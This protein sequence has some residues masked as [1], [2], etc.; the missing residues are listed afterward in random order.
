VGDKISIH[1][2]NSE[3]DHYYNYDITTGKKASKLIHSVKSL[4]VYVKEELESFNIPELV[5]FLLIP[6]LG[7]KDYTPP[8]SVVEYLLSLYEDKNQDIQAIYPLLYY[9]ENQKY[10]NSAIADLTTLQPVEIVKEI[11]PKSTKPN[12]SK[13]LLK[14]LAG[15]K[16][17]KKQ[18]KQTKKLPKKLAKKEPKK[19]TKKPVKLKKTISIPKTDKIPVKLKSSEEKKKV[20]APTKVK[21]SKKAKPSPPIQDEIEDLSIE[22]SIG[23]A[24]SKPVGTI[25][26]EK[27]EEIISAFDE[28]DEVEIYTPAIEVEPKYAKIESKIASVMR[29][30]REEIENRKRQLYKEHLERDRVPFEPAPKKVTLE[31]PSQISGEEFFGF[32]NIEWKQQAVYKLRNNPLIFYLTTISETGKETKLRNETTIINTK[33]AL[34]TESSKI[35]I[36]IHL[37]NVTDQFEL[38]IQAL[39]STNEILF[40]KSITMKRMDEITIQIEEFYVTGNYGPVESVF[41]AINKGL[42]QKGEFNMFLAGQTSTELI[43]IYSDKFNL[44]SNQNLE[45]ARSVDFL[46]IYHHSPF[47]LVSQITIGRLKKTRAYKAITINPIDD[48]LIEWDYTVPPDKPNLK[49]DGVLPKTKYEV[50][51]LFHFNRPLPPLTLTVYF[52]TLPEG[53]TQKLTTSKIKR[54]IDPGDEY[55]INKVKFKTPKNCGYMYFGVEILTDQGPIPTDLVSEPIGVPQKVLSS[56]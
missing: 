11:A 13:N 9:S 37:G 2:V 21:K 34:E 16:K 24:K 53:R 42:D 4:I 48:I 47:Y 10:T 22:Q 6:V 33:K 32:I 26:K 38:K 8:F 40:T 49:E 36:L 5:N 15:R 41:R 3:F 14:D 56:F 18:T 1:I 51:F 35:P 28:I 29:K 31:F 50:D 43:P 7:T 23:K 45:L 27:Q 20:E 30:R 44:K 52:N 12:L 17:P 46:P 39:T 25:Q 19:T 54:H 55:M